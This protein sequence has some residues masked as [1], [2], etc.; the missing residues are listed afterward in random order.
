[1]KLANEL[2]KEDKAILLEAV[3]DIRW[4][5]NALI[6]ELSNRGLKLTRTV[7]ERHRKKLCGCNA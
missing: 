4:T 7:I 3:V 2:S 5:P 1:M 6:V